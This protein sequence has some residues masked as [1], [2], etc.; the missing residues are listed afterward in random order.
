MR[1]AWTGPV[2]DGGGVPSMGK[3]LLR[4]LLRQ[5]VE[6]DLYLATDATVDALPVEPEPGLRV[7][8]RR[9]GWRWNRWYSSTKATA[10]VTSLAARS[11][12]AMLL[13]VRLLIE[14]RRRPYDAVY[15][16]SQTE[17]FALGRAR[18]FAPPIVVHP[19]T[20]AAGEL[21]WHRAE[22]G[23]ALKSERRGMHMTMRAVQA[24]RARLQPAELERA[25]LV[26]GLSER[27]VELVHQDYGVPRAKLRVVRHPVDLDRFTPA[28]TNGAAPPRTILFISRISAR[29]GV[30]DVIALSHRLADLEGSVRL[31][32]AGGPTLWSDYSAHL[33]DLHPGV[34]EY[35][36]NVPNRELPA[37]MRSAAL[38]IVPSRY[39]PGSIVTAEALAS[40]L[41]V[42]VSD[43]VGA[44]EVA[45][46]P[47]VR[48][49]RA[50]DLD[51]LEAA[52]RELLGDAGA[53]RARLAAAARAD[54]EAHFAPAVVAGRL[55]ELIAEVAGGKRP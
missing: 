38:L 14:H 46:G 22:Q 55:I 3:L 41:P 54:A 33:R 6:V 2:G 48:V 49:H 13:S 28:G 15:Q 27:F 53:D 44:G 19:C 31:L 1:I 24:A 30:E 42:V 52:V 47:H 43:E 25:D 39:E 20:H 4:E 10:F 5:G 8:V 37:L 23:Y 17:L 45:A 32:V 26:V 36:G 16:L 50:G 7:F 21:R 40:G 18:R 11:A 51:G 35:V 34:G 9:T 12:N 29:K